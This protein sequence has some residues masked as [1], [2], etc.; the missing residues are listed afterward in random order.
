MPADGEYTFKVSC[1]DG[2]DFRLGCPFS[3]PD[4][5]SPKM[6]GEFKDNYYNFVHSYNNQLKTPYAARIADRT[7]YL[8]FP[9]QTTWAQ[10][11]T[12]TLKAGRYPILGTHMSGS[13]DFGEYDALADGFGNEMV[14]FWEG[15]TFPMRPVA[16]KYVACTCIRTFRDA[17]YHYINP[18]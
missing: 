12:L 6:D 13:Q 9:T 11:K 5:C 4:W 1:S 10:T 17:G 15:P 3:D 7:G 14:L 16:S 18:S 2:C 8:R